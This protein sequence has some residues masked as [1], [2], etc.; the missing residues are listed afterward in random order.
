MLSNE[1]T[2]GK[3]FSEITI[4]QFWNKSGDIN[5]FSLADEIHDRT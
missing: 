1:N 2:R 5:L 4:F 3:K